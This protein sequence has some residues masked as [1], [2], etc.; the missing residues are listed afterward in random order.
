VPVGVSVDQSHFEVERRKR[1]RTAAR[2]SDDVTLKF[3]SWPRMGSRDS[4]A[5]T[6]ESV[7]VCSEVDD[8]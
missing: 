7:N 3:R 8:P 2:W 1:R 6:V 5:W 4:Y